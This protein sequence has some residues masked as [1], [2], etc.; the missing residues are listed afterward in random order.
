MELHSE[1]VCVQSSPWLFKMGGGVK[2]SSWLVCAWSCSE[3]SE[4][5]FWWTKGS[6]IGLT[7]APVFFS[8]EITGSNFSFV[9]L[10]GHVC[11]SALDLSL[12]FACLTDRPTS[13]SS[14]FDSLSWPV[15]TGGDEAQCPSCS[16][17]V[18][19]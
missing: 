2:E 3:V 18:Y 10:L 7:C 4:L 12:I 14:A 16:V 15:L 6:E 13:N 11:S 19:P 5:E 1:P 8:D 17:S 9:G